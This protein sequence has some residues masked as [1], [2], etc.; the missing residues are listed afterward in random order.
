MK[1]RALITTAIAINNFGDVL[2]DLFVAWGLNTGVGGFMGAV[3]VIGTSV[4]FRAFLSFFVGSFV[5][6]HPKKS[7][8]LASHCA[9]IIIIGLFGLLWSYI[10]NYIIIGVI[11]VLL[12]DVSNEVFLRSYISLTADKFEKNDYIK[13]QNMAS[14]ITRI[15]GIL[16]AAISG[17]IIQKLAFYSVFTIDVGTFLI[18]LMLFLMVEGDSNFVKPHNDKNSGVTLRSDIEYTISYIRNSSYIKRFIIIMVI[19]NLGYGF[20]P[21]ILPIIKASDLD[22]ASYLGLIKSFLVLGELIGLAL[23]TKF[24][25]HVS[26]SFKLSMIINF[27]VLLLIGIFQEKMIICILFLFYGA[28]DSLTQPFFNYTV[29]SLDSENRGKLLG[30]IDAIVMFSPSIGIYAISF[31]FACNHILG[32]ILLS[33]IFLVA[34]LLFCNSKEMNGLVLR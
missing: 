22:S 7:L 31:L 25:R 24:S 28:S 14:M 21:Q 23:A 18:S 20:I 19:L 34:Y 12:N 8:I 6:K 29:A 2:F 17:L 9:S 33:C 5:D 32:T 16:G 1:T 13:F 30:G 3:Y 15:V 11:F 26:T 27:F 4:G 10:Q